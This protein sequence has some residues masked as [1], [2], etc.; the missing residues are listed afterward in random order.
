MSIPRD[1]DEA[2]GELLAFSGDRERAA[3]SEVVAGVIGFDVAPEGGAQI[4]LGLRTEGLP[5]RSKAV[6]PPGEPEAR[7]VCSSPPDI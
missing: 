2:L 1:D 6:S 3:K 4:G 7:R 5:T